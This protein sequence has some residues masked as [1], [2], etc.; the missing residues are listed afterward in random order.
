MIGRQEP[1][2]RAVNRKAGGRADSPLDPDRRAGQRDQNDRPI[3]P[4][5]S[6]QEFAE[7]AGNA[8]ETHA[9]PIT[10]LTAPMDQSS[11]WRLTVL[12]ERGAMSKPSASAG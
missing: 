1:L 12:A 9:V 10:R 11:P 4:E 3:R 5:P 6:L 2:A 7:M 8:R